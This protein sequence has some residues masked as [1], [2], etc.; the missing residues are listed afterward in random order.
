M[1]TQ[2]LNFG[3]HT[4]TQFFELLSAR[5]RSSSPNLYWYLGSGRAKSTNGV[6]LLF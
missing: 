2:D 4:S 6:G 5:R 3:G 1:D